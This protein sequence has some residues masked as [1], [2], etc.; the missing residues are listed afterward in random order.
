QRTDLAAELDRLVEG[1]VAQVGHLDLAVGI[2][3][4]GQGV[5]HPDRVAF[6]QSFQLLDD[7]PVEVR[8]AE[9]EDYQLHRSYGHDGLL[10]RAGRPVLRS[11]LPEPPPRP[12]PP[13]DRPASPSANEA[14]RAHRPGGT[15]S[16]MRVRSRKPAA[17]WTRSAIGVDWRLAVV[18]PR[19][20]VACR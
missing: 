20:R 12:S 7:L 9:P 2:L 19:A 18:Q 6:A 5:D 4:H 1:E 11:W 17:A 13:V 8:V 15:N 10:S 14:G 3:V 16:R